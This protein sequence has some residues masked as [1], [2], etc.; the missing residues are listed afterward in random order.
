MCCRL[1]LPNL[2]ITEKAITCDIGL[3]TQRDGRSGHTVFHTRGKYKH[4]DHH[5]F[6]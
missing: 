6:Q 2:E 4:D 3:N 5:C 1:V